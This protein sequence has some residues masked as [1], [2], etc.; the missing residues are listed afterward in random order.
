M[1]VKN[2]TLFNFYRSKSMENFILVLEVLIYVNM[3]TL[4]AF[5]N[6]I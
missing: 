3:V 6:L 4:L 5:Y 1:S 2:Y